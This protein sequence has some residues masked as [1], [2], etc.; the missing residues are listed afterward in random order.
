M[1]N[2]INNITVDLPSFSRDR[3]PTTTSLV[4]TLLFDDD[5]TNEIEVKLDT[6]YQNN[7]SKNDL[8]SKLFSRDSDLTSTN[9]RPSVSP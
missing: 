1:E 2:V 6:E 9:V 8:L 7:Y 4:T 5:S 3:D